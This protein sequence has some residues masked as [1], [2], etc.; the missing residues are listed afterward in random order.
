MKKIDCFG[1]T[2]MEVL[3]VLAII[4]FLMGM[5]LSG[6][7]QANKRARIYKTKAM[8]ASL[9]TALALYHTDF[10]FYPASGNQNM[11]NS[12][13][14]PAYASEDDWH[15]PYMSFKAEDLSG[16]MPNATVIDPWGT[17]YSYALGTVP[18]YEIKSWGP[19]KANNTSD[20]ISS[21]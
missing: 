10:G 18:A 19:D 5:I 11:V 13:A 15:G 12:L 7:N 16:V 3:A 6:G 20:D 1:F 17:D 4:S 21:L 14:G 8:I 2:L 9:D